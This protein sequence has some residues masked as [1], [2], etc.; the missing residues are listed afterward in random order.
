[1]GAK[2]VALAGLLIASLLLALYWTQLGVE[3]NGSARVPSAPEA[4]PEEREPDALVP[5]SAPIRAEVRGERS[6]GSD[7]DDEPAPA[8]E[9]APAALREAIDLAGTLIVVDAQG[10]EHPAESGTFAL[11]LW[12]GDRGSWREIEVRNGRWNTLVPPEEPFEA[13]GVDAIRV[14]QRQALPLEPKGR[15]PLP[16]TRWLVLRARWP[17]ESL[18]HVRDQ[19]T[20]AELAPVSMVEVEDW[21]AAQFGHPGSAAAEAR[22]FGPSPLRI[23]TDA[24]RLDTRTFFARSPGYAWGRIEI[25]E[26]LGGER[27]LGLQPAGELEVRLEGNVT[28]PG[29]RLR[30]YGIEHAPVFERT[31]SDASPVAIDALVPG[32]YRLAVEIGNYWQD[33]LVLAET[34]VDVLAGVRTPALLRLEALEEP[35]SVPFAGVLVL[36]EE[37]ELGEFELVFELLDTVLGGGEG[38]FSIASRDMVPP[39]GAGGIRHWSSESVQPGTYAVQLRSLGFSAV[40]RVGPEGER[41]ARIEVPPPG[42][43]LLRCVDEATGLEAVGLSVSW[44]GPVPPELHGWS[45]EPAVWDESARGWRIRAPQG[46]LSLTAF[47]TAFGNQTR[48][49]ELHAGTQELTWR[50]ARLT[51]L[52]LV[53]RDGATEIPWTQQMRA[54]LDA[55]EGQADMRSA[56]FGNGSYT[57]LKK[58]PGGYRLHID[59]IPGYEP[60]PDLDVRLEAGVVTERVIELVRAR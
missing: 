52:R 17:S 29:T 20:G 32:S 34:S 46:T 57:L 3:R 24:Q 33:P 41:N 1:M 25:D 37:W 44:H 39:G 31:L 15:F 53:L 23:P 16:D 13:L 51:G 22:D 56:Q 8:A 26:R 60:V 30:L 18:L 9:G 10:V 5:A 35:A 48:K 58:E 19:T 36:P 42:L 45:N 12:R 38:S 21:P 49:L 6:E 40:L 4:P 43:V 28:D 59:P 14:G 47:G 27:F 55:T 7:Q 11:V 54:R 50:L 2:Q